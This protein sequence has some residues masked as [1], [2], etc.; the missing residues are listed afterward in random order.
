MRFAHEWAAICACQEEPGEVE[1]RTGLRGGRLKKS[2]IVSSRFSSLRIYGGGK[3]GRPNIFDLVTH[4]RGLCSEMFFLLLLN[5]KRCT[6]EI[7]KTR[8]RL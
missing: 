2:G 1:I 7:L 6:L 4:A 3:Q 8:F 5:G